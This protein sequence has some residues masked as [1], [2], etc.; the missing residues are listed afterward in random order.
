MFVL[1][2][3]LTAPWPV[4]WKGVDA[5]GQVVDQSLTLFFRRVG[6]E[7]FR[8]L[9]ESAEETD[10]PAIAARNRQLFDRLVAGWEGVVDAGGRPLPFAAPA[11]GALLDYPGFAEAFGEAYSRFWLA[12]PEE[13]EKNSVPSPA[14]G[15]ATGPN[16]AAGTAGTASRR[17]SARRAPTKP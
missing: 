5:S 8:R 4:S 6:V 10:G 13:R 1:V 11:I 14:G 12:I 9:F 15:R 16:H 2:T 17:R 3:D 7:E